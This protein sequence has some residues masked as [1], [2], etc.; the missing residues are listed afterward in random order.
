MKE[1][2]K[3]IGDNEACSKDIKYV[4][5]I[6]ENCEYIKIPVENFSTLNIDASNHEGAVLECVIKKMNDIEYRPFTNDWNPFTRLSMLNDIASIELEFT[7][8][9]RHSIQPYW[10]GIDTNNYCQITHVISW[11][12]ISITIC[13]E[14]A[15]KKMRARC[16]TKAD[17]ILDVLYQDFHIDTCDNC[18]YKEDCEDLRKEN[19][20]IT[21]CDILELMQK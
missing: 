6:L 8:G 2:I 11:D 16:G 18:C 13:E 21:I 1:Y 17:R 19:N 12:K 10:R 14:N 15:M 4:T 9:T 7:N 20:D 5:F 3:I